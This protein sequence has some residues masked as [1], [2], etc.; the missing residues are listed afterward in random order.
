VYAYGK[1]DVERGVGRYVHRPPFA[2]YYDA[3]QIQA[4]RRQ[5]TPVR[6]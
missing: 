4:Q 6:R 5:P 3:L 1:L 2:S